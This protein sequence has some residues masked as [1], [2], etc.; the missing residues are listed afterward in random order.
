MRKTIKWLGVLMLVAFI[1]ALFLI[2]SVNALTN[3]ALDEN[4][5]IWKGNSPNDKNNQGF[6]TEFGK[7]H[8]LGKYAEFRMMFD[9]KTGVPLY[10]INYE[11]EAGNTGVVTDIEDTATWK[12]LTTEAQTGIILSTLYG[13]PISS[14]GT[15]ETAA[16]VATQIVIWEYQMG[17]RTKYNVC[18]NS[19]WESF[20]A[21][22]SKLTIAY[23]NLLTQIGAHINKPDFYTTSIILNGVGESYGVYIQD[24]NECLED[25][26]WTTNNPNVKVEVLGTL[27]HIYATKPIKDEVRIE[28]RR[29]HPAATI[30]GAEVYVGY[31]VFAGQDLVGGSLPDPQ[32]AAMLR[33]DL[34]EAYGN[35]KVVKK[36][37][38]GDV[39][40]YKFSLAG[41]DYR[42]N[43]VSC[44]A[45][46]D[47]NGE[48]F[49]EH[50][51]LQM[52]GTAY[53][54]TETSCDTSTHLLPNPIE[55]SLVDG[56]TEVVTV[57]N[58]H[59]K[60]RVI[61]TKIGMN[62]VPL[63]GAIFALYKDNIEVARYTTDANG[64]FTTEYYVCGDGYILKEIEA[65]PGY[66]CNPSAEYDPGFTPNSTITKEYTDQALSITNQPTSV[67]IVKTDVT[68]SAPVVGATIEIYNDQNVKV[69][70]GVTDDAGTIT[71]FAL[72]IGT[73]TFKETAA[74][75]GYVLNTDSFTFAINDDGGIS[76]TTELTNKKT[77]ITITKTDITTSEPIVGATIE[78]YDEHGS[79]VYESV[80]DTDG[81]ITA[82]G[83][84]VGKYTFKETVAPEGYVINANSFGFEI[85]SDGS[86]SGVTEFTNEKTKVTITKT[87]LT[88]TKPVAGATVEIYNEQGVKVYSAI[89]NDKG[90]IT[91][92]GLPLGKYTFKETIAPEGYGLNKE[93]FEFE[94][95]DDGSVSGV[96]EFVNEITK[97]TI[98]KTDSTT[99]K[100][101]EGA[102]VEIYNEN[103][104]L[105]HSAV[106]DENG[107][108]TAI[109][110]PV[111]KYA[112]K[113]TVAP[114]GYKLNADSFEFEILSDG[115]V[116]GITEFTNERTG[117]VITKIDKETKL[118][119]KGAKITVY[120]ASGIVV[121]EG[122]TNENGTV[123]I[124]GLPAG[125]YMFYETK[126]PAG[127][128][129]N[130]SAFFFK[131]NP[132]GSVEGVLEIENKK[133]DV[134]LPNTGDEKSLWMSYILCFASIGIGAA[135]LIKRK[136][137]A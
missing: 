31:G 50:I 36:E 118:P 19:P 79:K 121:F 86:V 9:S 8:A 117:V 51:P 65:S 13:Y 11:A 27:L 74:P 44:T 127:Y 15:T 55:V 17:Y 83:L 112:F 7:Y 60:A 107:K 88:T 76:G 3:D 37:E 125:D 47:K 48:A 81:E 97:V 64:Q 10:C 94:I 59:K 26:A 130:S 22:N 1:S 106:T 61:V 14:L 90:E 91:A 100:P 43:Q 68:T 73:Y 93:T 18:V 101:V 120:N 85:M 98:T 109:G 84:P 128:E 24:K 66:I 63:P 32:P 132:D 119:L 95:L 34:K 40:G 126:A 25:F 89:T 28:A 131:I 57:N 82:I 113:E 5:D 116:V 42:G 56:Q 111:G 69:Y 103:N 135:L 71:A 49:F 41:I 75:D 96:T 2:P 35:L 4:I 104:E 99:S 78:I 46:T 137:S 38:C 33:V 108:I 6:L 58:V 53:T 23:N 114:S 77:E 52:E 20:V 70:S 122:E 62:S 67:T 92:F 133:M 115:S 80:T 129:R 105:M 102:T 123:N 16:Y 30:G 136:K 45:T 21:N 39:S 134:E 29:K 124:V 110:L 54:L 72:P 12:S 87:S